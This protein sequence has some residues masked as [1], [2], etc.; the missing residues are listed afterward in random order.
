MATIKPDAIPLSHP[1]K[2]VT[3]QTEL[4]LHKEIVQGLVGDEVADVFY[5]VR[6]CGWYNLKSENVV[7]RA[8]RKILPYSDGT[9]RTAIVFFKKGK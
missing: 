5:N 3:P 2:W 9:S 7:V 4:P 6:Q 8:W 1:F